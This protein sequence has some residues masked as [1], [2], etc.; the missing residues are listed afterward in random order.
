MCPRTL[1]ANQHPRYTTVW[2]KR[3]ILAG[4]GAWTKDAAQ[5]AQS[6]PPDLADSAASI[7]TA[8]DIQNLQLTVPIHAWIDNQPAPGP[9]TYTQLAAFNLTQAGVANTFSGPVQTNQ[10]SRKPW[11]KWYHQVYKPRN[12]LDVKYLGGAVAT[13]DENQLSIVSAVGLECQNALRYAVRFR[14]WFED[15]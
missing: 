13:Y 9:F 4:L 3:G 1:L 11:K 2:S 8:G 7:P 15:V 12:G 14:V 5:N 10:L 6:V